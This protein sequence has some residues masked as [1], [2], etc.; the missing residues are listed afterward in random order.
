MPLVLADI[1][2]LFKQP[3]TITEADKNENL[4]I[5]SLRILPAIVN[6]RS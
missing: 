2:E 5:E 3:H 1:C 4:K 6:C